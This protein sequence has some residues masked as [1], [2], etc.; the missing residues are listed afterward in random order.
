[1][2][3]TPEQIHAALNARPE[4]FIYFSRYEVYRDSEGVYAYEEKGAWVRRAT[5]PFGVS[6]GSIEESPAVTL[7]L[8]DSPEHSHQRIRETYPSDWKAPAVITAALGE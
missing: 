3:P 8:T 7:T 6:E 1:M 4:T 5:P 2:R